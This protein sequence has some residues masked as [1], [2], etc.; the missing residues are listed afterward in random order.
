MNL[1][2]NCLDCSTLNQINPPSQ[3]DQETQSSCPAFLKCHQSL[4][5]K[6]CYECQSMDPDSSFPARLRMR[7]V[8]RGNSRHSLVGG[9]TSRKTPISRSAL[10]KNVMPWHLYEGK[11]VDE[12]T[13]RRGT[14]T[15]HRPEKPAGY[16]HS[17][18]SGLSAREQLERQVEFHS[19]TQ[20]ETWFSVPTLQGNC[21][22]SQYQRQET[23]ERKHEV[24][25]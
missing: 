17:S 20:D 5:W 21:D 13:T 15:V 12:S 25:A 14:D 19:S 4:I 23:Q 2:D 10:D 22:P 24:P 8:S 18:T 3:C 9:A 6:G 11:P 1:N 16:K 7:Q